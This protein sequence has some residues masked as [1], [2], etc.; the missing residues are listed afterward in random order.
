MTTGPSKEELQDYWANNRQYF[1]ELA[2]YYLQADREYYSKYIAPFYSNPFK[3]SSSSKGGG[4]AKLLVVFIAM[5]GV[6]AAGAAAFLV[7][8]TA[9][10]DNEKI[11]SPKVVQDS[12]IKPVTH[13]DKIPDT[14]ANIPPA[15]Q[16]PDYNKGLKYF[17][18]KDYN[19]AEKYFK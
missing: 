8:M 18:N 2:K 17:L 12:I 14:T 19:N 1:D 6:I 3:P 15:L 10:D 11:I 5:I 4:T 9:K 16:S 13:S 7:L